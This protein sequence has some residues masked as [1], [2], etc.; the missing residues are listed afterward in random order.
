MARNK[1]KNTDYKPEDIAFPDQVIVESGF[2]R[3]EDVYLN[4][5][6]EKS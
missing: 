6:E 2:H 3:K 1:S 4:V 5:A